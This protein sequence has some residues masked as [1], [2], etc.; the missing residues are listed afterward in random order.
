MTTGRR[1]TSHAWIFVTFAAAGAG[2][3]AFTP[4]RTTATQSATWIDVTATLDPATTPVYDGNAPLRFEFWKDMRKGDGV[5]SRGTK[6]R[7]HG[8]CYGI[9]ELLTNDSRLPSRDHEGTLIVPRLSLTATTLRAR[10]RAEDP[11]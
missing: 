2:I 4:Q 5:R 1:S 9:A 10:L 11:S 7:P 6:A 8:R 3:M